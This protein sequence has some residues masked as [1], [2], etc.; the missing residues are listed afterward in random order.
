MNISRVSGDTAMLFSQITGQHEA[1]RRLAELVDNK[2]L[3]H[4]L[5]LDSKQGTGAL[6]L[7][8]ALAQ[9]IHCRDRQGGDACGV[10]PACVK[11]NAA[12]HPDTHFIFPVNTSDMAEAAGNLDIKKPV[13]DHFIAPWREQIARTGGYLSEQMWYRA[14]GIDNK[15]GNISKSEAN[16]LIRKMGFK[17]F[18][19]DYKIVVVWLPERMNESAANT[20]LK[21]IEEPWE[22]TLF[23]FVSEQSDRI[24]K[25]ILS[26]TQS[27]AVPPIDTQSLAAHLR[28]K[29]NA[30]PAK[31]EAV[32]LLS[33][34]DRIGA[35][36][37]MEDEG[38]EEFDRFMQLMRLCYQDKHLDLL[39]WS[40]EAAALG[41]EEQK[42]MLEYLLK[43]FRSNYMLS[44]GM[45][46]LSHLFGRELETCRKLA[47]YIN[48]GNIEKLIAETEKTI[49]HI[50]Q[51]GNPRIVL[52]HYVLTISK[53]IST[54]F[55]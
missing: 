50:G 27:I 52:T 3:G 24:I 13:S 2:R 53:L 12:A 48:N 19:S 14:I 7:A 6:P 49:R 37:I 25:T 21:L 15:Q 29:Y 33:L 35:E 23:V 46:E 51:N 11:M 36:K 1:K 18:E 41:R 16:E 31:A 17:P 26:R 5:L 30:D 9:Y 43:M 28:R 44:M 40:E 32:A 55:K 42:A 22:N 8:I 34:G 39:N 45:E 10:C 47:P 4:A 54:L 38:E 20:L